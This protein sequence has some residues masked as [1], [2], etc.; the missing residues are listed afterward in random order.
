LDKGILRLDPLNFGVADGTISGNLVL[1]GQNKISH[2]ESDLLIKRLS[3]KQFF[4]DPEFEALSAGHF[5]GQLKLKGR[6]V[7]W[8]TF[9]PQVMAA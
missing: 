5:G 2:V 8:L 1:D 9:W 4:N 7:P 3:M 6:G